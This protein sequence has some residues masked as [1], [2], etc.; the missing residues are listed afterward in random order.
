M[1]FLA[2]IELA[3]LTGVAGVLSAVAHATVLCILVL[4]RN[5][6]EKIHSIA[7]DLSLLVCLPAEVF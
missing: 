6:E 4:L 5:S 3:F 7:T 1:T 2:V